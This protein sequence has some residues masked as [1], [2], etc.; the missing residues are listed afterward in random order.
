MYAEIQR[1]IVADQPS[2]WMYTEA[3]L[4]GFHESVKGY[5]PSPMYPI[6]VLFQDL[7]LE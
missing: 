6:T 4:L 2:V 7:W 1:L 5:V 3:Q